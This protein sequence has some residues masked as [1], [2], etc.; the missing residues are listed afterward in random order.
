MFSVQ[1]LVRPD[2]RNGS[3]SHRG[4]SS[5]GMM[6]FNRLIDIDDTKSFDSDRC[7]S[8]TEL[9]EIPFSAMFQNSPWTIMHV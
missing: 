7:I 9:V 5:V 3:F 4:H 8:Q 1:Q 6:K 2:S